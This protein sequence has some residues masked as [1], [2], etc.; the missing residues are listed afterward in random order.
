MD[1]TD[2]SLLICDCCRQGVTDV[3]PYGVWSICSSCLEM[4]DNERKKRSA[5][6][7]LIPRPPLPEYPFMTYGRE[8]LI[9]FSTWVHLAT[10][11]RYT[12]IGVGLCSTN[13]D[14]EHKEEAVIYVSHAHGDLRYREIHEFLSYNEHGIPRFVPAADEGKFP[15][16]GSSEI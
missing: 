4:M 3:E 16:A 1:E 8:H 5:P 11:S 14:N 15:P 12:V 9:P 13:G 7:H 10:R 2:R 6:G